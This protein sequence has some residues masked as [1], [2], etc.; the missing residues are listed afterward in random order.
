MTNT[1]PRDK[2][3]F[4]GGDQEQREETLRHRLLDVVVLTGGHETSQRFCQAEVEEGGGWGTLRG[5]G[6]VTTFVEHAKN[7]LQFCCRSSKLY[8]GRGVTID[9]FVGVS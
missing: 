8:I 5:V 2:P 3:V 6:H 9:R 7:L 1:C 4:S